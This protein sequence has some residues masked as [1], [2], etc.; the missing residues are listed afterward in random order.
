M[1]FPST[2]PVRGPDKGTSIF[3]PLLSII[4]NDVIFAIGLPSPGRCVMKRWCVQ[5]SISNVWNKSE[6]KDGGRWD[7]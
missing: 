2:R 6:G 7:F 5:Q 1:L 3:L 4:E